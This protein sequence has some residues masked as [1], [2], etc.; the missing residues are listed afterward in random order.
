MRQELDALAAAYPDRFQVSYSLTAPAASWAGHTGRGSVEMIRETLPPPASRGGEDGTTMLLVCG[1]DGFV[2]TWA[3]PVGRG[4]K[5]A[6][7]SKGGKIQ[8]PLLGLLANAGYVDAEVFK[9]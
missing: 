9:Y 4:P 8:G 2:A 3:G 6:D 1:T 5:K 7:G